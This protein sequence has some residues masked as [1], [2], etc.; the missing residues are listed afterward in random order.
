MNRLAPAPVFAVLLAARYCRSPPDIAG[1]RDLLPARLR[2][3]R[4]RVASRARSTL[5]IILSIS[6]FLGFCQVQDRGRFT[7]RISLSLSLLSTCG[8]ISRQGLPI[9]GVLLAGQRSN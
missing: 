3:D 6:F 8:I 9:T 4:D 1:G 7:P 2:I 5:S